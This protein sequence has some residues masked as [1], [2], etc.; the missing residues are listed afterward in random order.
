MTRWLGD[1]I[2]QDANLCDIGTCGSVNNWPLW[3]GAMR[4]YENVGCHGYA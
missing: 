4:R 1:F 2:G 3:Q